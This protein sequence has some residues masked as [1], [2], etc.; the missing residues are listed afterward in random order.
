MTGTEAAIAAEADKIRAHRKAEKQLE[1]KA[2]YE[3]ELAALDADLSPPQLKTPPP[4]PITTP[5]RYPVYPQPETSHS[6]QQTTVLVVSSDSDTDPN[7]EASNRRFPSPTPRVS[8][9]NRKPSRRLESQRRRAAEEESEPKKKK[10]RKAKLVDVTSQL[11]ELLGSDI[12][13]SA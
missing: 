9:R 11:K 7:S 6:T 13:F 1:I 4:P 5:P 10:I 2:K 3:A 12:E 8:A